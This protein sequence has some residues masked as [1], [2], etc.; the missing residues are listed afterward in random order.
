MVEMDRA[1]RMRFVIALALGLTSLVASVSVG[2]IVMVSRMSRLSSAIESAEDIAQIKEN[3]SALEETGGLL[4]AIP[5]I[6]LSI[7]IVCLVYCFL[8]WGSSFVGPKED[9]P[10]PSTAGTEPPAP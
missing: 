6:S 8:I 7:A 4:T 1:R 9:T 2:P 3:I 5:V 10:I